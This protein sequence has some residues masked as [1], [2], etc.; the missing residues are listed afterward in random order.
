M[1]SFCIMHTEKRHATDAH[2]ISAENNREAEKEKDFPASD[3]N[4]KKTGDNIYFKKS[5]NWL[6]DIKKELHAH[7]INKWRKDAVMFL[8]TVYSASPEF[9]A[10]KSKKE[11]EAYFRNCLAFNEREYGAHTINA[12]IHLDETTPHMHV[13]CVPIAEKKPKIEK[14]ENGL[15]KP[16][17]KEYTLSSKKVVGNKVQMRNAQTHFY[18]Q[19][20]REWG[21]ERGQTND[22][23]RNRKHLNSLEYKQ[24]MEREKTLALS[25]QRAQIERQRDQ[26]LKDLKE[27]KG[28]VAKG[29]QLSDKYDNF[30]NKFI[31]T[32][33][34]QGR[35]IIKMFEDMER[36]EVEQF[37]DGIEDVEIDDF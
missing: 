10:G 20:G 21:L 7:G 12:V 34:E 3:I 19:V 18:N 9:F 6:A 13:I 25:Q 4:W 37:F 35:E 11:I 27:I 8:D 29:Q 5:D 14:D 36:Q 23:E 2:G 22:P 16:T 24:R 26:S 33:G 30:V 15:I 17:K 31:A 1:A 28:K 32:Y